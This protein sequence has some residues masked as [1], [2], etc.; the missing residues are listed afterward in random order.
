METLLRKNLNIND[1]VFIWDKAKSHYLT[2]QDYL[3]IN[4]NYMFRPTASPGIKNFNQAYNF[5]DIMAIE[6]IFSTWK[7]KITKEYIDTEE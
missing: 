5:I 3:K 7:R 6:F 4:L 2:N 1:F